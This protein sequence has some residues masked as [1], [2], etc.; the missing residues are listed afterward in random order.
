MNSQGYSVPVLESGL[1]SGLESHVQVHAPEQGFGSGDSTRFPKC[2]Q[3]QA[4]PGMRAK[5]FLQ[6][7]LHSRS[8][9]MAVAMVPLDDG[10]RVAPP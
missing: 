5:H 2:G 7:E 10:S 8:R 4:D 9:F 1:F 3:G 6:Q